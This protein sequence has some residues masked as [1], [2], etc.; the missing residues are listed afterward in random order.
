MPQNRDDLPRGFQEG[1]L[2]YPP[3]AIEAMGK[4]FFNASEG[5]HLMFL[6]Y[7]LDFTFGEFLFVIR[8]RSAVSIKVRLEAFPNSLPMA[9]L[10]NI[11]QR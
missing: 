1:C 6:S 7:R 10:A 9:L 3:V 8:L 2:V 5:G 11:L 4:L